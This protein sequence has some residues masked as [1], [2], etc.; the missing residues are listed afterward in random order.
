[1]YKLHYTIGSTPFTCPCRDAMGVL[2]SL[3]DI[4]VHDLVTKIDFDEAVCVLADMIKG[5]SAGYIADNISVRK[6]A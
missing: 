5:D 3:R 1:M 2:D 4:A 6:E